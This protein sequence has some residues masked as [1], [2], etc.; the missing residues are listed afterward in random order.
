MSKNN[1]AQSRLVLDRKFV[2]DPEEWPRWPLLPVK[3]R[4]GDQFHQHGYCGFMFA[5]GRP[6]VYLG[7][8]Y[9]LGAG[10]PKTWGE[11]LSKYKAVE[12]AD[13]DALLSV[14]TVD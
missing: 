10:Y 5:D 9:E 6:R 11:A 1:Q 3:R 2:S 8:M 7:Y 12:Y 4:D 13:V 14:W